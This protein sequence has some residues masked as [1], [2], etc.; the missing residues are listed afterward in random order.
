MDIMQINK[1]AQT[2]DMLIWIYRFF[3]IVLIALA[4]ILIIG[5]FLYMKYD[6]RSA[7]A[8]LLE[9]KAADCLTDKGIIINENLN[10]DKLKECTGLSKLNSDEL[11]NYY[12]SA[13]LAYGSNSKI[14]EAGDKDLKE[15]CGLTG[16]VPACNSANY[17]VLVND[18]G[19]QG[20]K[21]TISAAILKAGEG[22]M[23]I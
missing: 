14:L 8:A 5:N 22:E 6:V 7:E 11:K 10:N 16:K 2:G 18:N 3:L 17:Y 1:K 12:V 13:N 4:Y 19:I 9:K 23:N 21:L 15:L 20:A